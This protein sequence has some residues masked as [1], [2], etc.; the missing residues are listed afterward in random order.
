M[1][2]ESASPAAV[3]S[4]AAAFRPAAPPF[5]FWPVSR[6]EFYQSICVG[7]MPALAWGVI[8]F[9]GR[10]LAMTA[11]AVAAS[12]VTYAALKRVLNWRRARTMPYVH[13]LAS[14]LV[15]VALAHPTWPVWFVTVLALALPLLLVIVGGAGKERVHVAALLALAAPYI[16]QAMMAPTMYTGKA[17]AVL[18][19]DRLVLGDV[20]N[21]AGDYLTAREWPT[22]R[23]LGGNDAVIYPAPAAMAVRALNAVAAALPAR[24]EPSADH[25]PDMLLAAD[26]AKI[27]GILDGALATELPRMDT[28]LLGVAP[29]RAGAASLAGLLLA[30]LYLSYR[31]ILRPRSAAF[32]V[33]IFVLTTAFLAFT[34]ATL[35]R[36]GV[37]VV[38]AV[39]R[40]FPGE[41][42]TL[43]NFLLWNSDMPFAAVIILALP[44]TEP[45][46]ARGRRVF[47][48]MAA[49]GAAALHRLDPT[50]PAATLALCVLM[51]AAPLFD[52]VLKQRSWVNGAA[53]G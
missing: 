32:F 43:F 44:G 31:H 53:G 16:M 23:E 8:L 30:G 6:R 5:L 42:L 12:S 50:A 35:E 26:I 7:L 52:R 21:Q 25:V 28:F 33:G 41:M 15:L 9:G 29:N 11:L 34:P 27:R 19:R 17:D 3:H 45:L 20:Q 39:V 24:A 2:P 37:L 48:A 40:N 36:T 22:A 49:A 13:C 10:V 4:R 18:A 47:L 51:P 38:G 1:A 14:D 46:T